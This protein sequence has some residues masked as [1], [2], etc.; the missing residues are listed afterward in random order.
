LSH[1]H[2]KCRVHSILPLA[3]RTNQP[4][5]HIH[6]RDTRNS[7]EESEMLYSNTDSKYTAVWS[8]LGFNWQPQEAGG[9]YITQW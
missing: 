5:L 2:P 1:L 8:S 4:T 9:D 6:T 3:P 7:E